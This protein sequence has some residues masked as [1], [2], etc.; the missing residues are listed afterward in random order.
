MLVGM[1]GAGSWAQNT[2]EISYDKQRCQGGGFLGVRHEKRTG[3]ACM[4]VEH[5]LVLVVSGDYLGL[6]LTW[7]SMEESRDKEPE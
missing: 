6:M 4:H 3:Y 1:E 5:D 2:K 7:L